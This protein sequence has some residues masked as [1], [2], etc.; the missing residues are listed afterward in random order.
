MSLANLIVLLVLGLVVWGVMRPT[1]RAWPRSW[2]TNEDW[3]DGF[4]TAHT[5]KL[6]QSLLPEI[7]QIVVAR[8]LYTLL[9]CAYLCLALNS[10]TG[11]VL[12]LAL[13]AG[14]ALLARN[15]RI[16]VKGTWLESHFSAQIHAFWL[17]LAAVALIDPTRMRGSTLFASFRRSGLDCR[18][19][20]ATRRRPGNGSGR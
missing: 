11:L 16:D 3:L 2:P 18:T 19:C 9:G 7:Y 20:R 10:A 8:A 14:A 12:Y 1:R 4:E 15:Y 6:P 5:G 17:T 13:S